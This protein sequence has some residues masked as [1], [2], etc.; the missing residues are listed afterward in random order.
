MRKQEATRLAEMAAEKAQYQAV[1]AQ[2]E[3]VSVLFIKCNY[4]SSMQFLESLSWFT[5]LLCEKN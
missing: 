5:V 2:K 1:M 3:V 4:F